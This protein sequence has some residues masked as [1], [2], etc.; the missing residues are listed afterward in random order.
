MAAPQ[1]TTVPNSIQTLIE[2]T[3]RLRAAVDLTENGGPDAFAAPSR[4][5][6]WT[7]G[8]VVSHL[9]RNADG[10]HRV[11]DG[12]AAGQQVKPYDSPQARADDIEAGAQR[13]T[14]TIAADFRSADRQ[15]ARTI[16]SL[17]AE[18][19]AATV[20][21]GRGGPATADVILA[22]RLG[23][24]EIHHHDL[25]VDDGLAL[26][27]DDQANRLLAALLR[28]YVRTRGVH[29]LVLAPDGRTADHRRIRRD[30]RRGCRH[31]SGR[32]AQRPGGRCGAADRGRTS[33]AAVLVNT[34]SAMSNDPAGSDTNYTGHVDPHGAPAT[35]EL[36]DLTITKLSV[37]PMDNNAYLLVCKHTGGAVLIDA[38]NDAD[39]IVGLLGDGPDGPALDA[40]VTTHG[41]YDH[42]QALAAVADRTGAKVYA[43]A[44]DAADVPV[45]TDVNLEHGDT[46]AVGDCRLRRDRVARPHPRVGGAA[47]HRSGRSS[48]LVHR[49]LAVPRRTG[50]DQHAADVRV[51]DERP[52]EPGVRAAAG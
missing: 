9:A 4:L 38:A 16:E 34:V 44:A 21:L 37:G 45:P 31:R 41:H 30:H 15:L 25:G 27:D 19:W 46:V 18:L 35:R 40:I 39:R 52:G 12:V 42:W 5:P 13:G 43:G 14:A 17:D 8:H 24:V 2:A 1:Q 47:V 7:I 29:D 10:L 6:D 51:P 22:A 49:R 3:A 11:L 23:E 32:L 26:L 28:S 50:K 33:R 36:A 48:A 20:D